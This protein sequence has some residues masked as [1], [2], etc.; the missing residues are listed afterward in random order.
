M[1]PLT[2]G[3]HAPYYFQKFKTN[4]YLAQSGKADKGWCGYILRDDDAQNTDKINLNDAFNKYHG[5]FLFAAVAPRLDSHL[6]IK[7]FLSKIWKF[8]DGEYQPTPFRSRAFI[9]LHNPEAESYDKSNLS[10]FTFAKL[11][12]GIYLSSDFNA[13]CC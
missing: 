9:W 10:S 4:L 3:E 8:L 7:N 2:T 12:D 6:E 1:N 11:P 13:A 5:T